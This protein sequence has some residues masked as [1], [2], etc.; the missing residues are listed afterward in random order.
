LTSNSDN[1]TDVFDLALENELAPYIHQFHLH[2]LPFTTD[3]P[4]QQFYTNPEQE[5]HLN[6][7]THLL[8]SSDLVLVLSGETGSGKS[9]LILQLINRNTPG[10]DYCQITASEQMNPEALLTQLTRCFELPEQLNIQTTLELLKDHANILRTNNRVPVAII[11][12][13]HELP[14]D[15]LKVLLSLQQPQENSTPDHWH[16]LLVTNPAFTADLLQLN[17]RL[18]FVHL[19]PLDLAQTRDY[20]NH[21]MIISGFEGESPFSDKDID[22]IFQQSQGLP[23]RIHQLAH[24]ILMQKNPPVASAQPVTIKQAPETRLH[25]R[26][27]FIAGTL[28]I[29]LILGAALLFQDDINSLFDNSRNKQAST[30]QESLPLPEN[31]KT[32]YL[33]RKIP[34]PAPA[35]PAITNKPAP[36]VKQLPVIHDKK[37]VVV[38]A[39]I[40]IQPQV[41]KKPPVA[42]QPTPKPVISTSRI[43][44]NFEHKLKKNMIFTRSWIMQQQPSHFTAQIMASSQVNNLIKQASLPGMKGKTAIYGIQRKGKNWYVLLF[45]HKSDRLAIKTAIAG[46]P[47]HLQKNRPWIRSFSAIQS[48]IS[49][50]KK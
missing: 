46:L 13:A 10:L 28:A 42:I 18:H 44:T 30:A 22:F 45:G 50:G 21:R 12:D 41:S 19:N 15:S 20:I 3:I 33:L 29:I 34:D 2:T 32:A 11:D 1:R 47:A 38:K 27:G 14:A 5:Q 16:V 17:D 35:K 25:Q 43:D 6:H 9:S 37:P 26:K 40:K 4:G 31:S 48:E 36:I 7:L 24:Q 49:A 39:G 23:K 8:Q